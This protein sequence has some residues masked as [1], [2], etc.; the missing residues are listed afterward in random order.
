MTDQWVCQHC[1]RTKFMVP[2]HGTFY[3]R[4]PREW[5]GDHPEVITRT[6]SGTSPY[7]TP[8]IHPNDQ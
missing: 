3:L 6:T 1:G 8:P 5:D 4:C 2:A 7:S